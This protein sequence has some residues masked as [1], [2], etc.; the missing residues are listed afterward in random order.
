MPLHDTCIMEKGTLPSTTEKNCGSHLLEK[1]WSH[2]NFANILPVKYHLL[3]AV[4]QVPFHDC[5]T[6]YQLWLTVTV[7]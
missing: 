2:Q 6:M 1:I 3:F 5:N 4:L 7:T